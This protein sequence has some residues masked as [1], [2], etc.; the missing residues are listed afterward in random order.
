MGNST[1]ETVKK[2]DPNVPLKSAL[3]KPTGYS[4]PNGHQY[5]PTPYP[6]EPYFY[7]AHPAY[8]PVD[9]NQ[10]HFHAHSPTKI[11]R[12]LMSP[13]CFIATKLLLFCFRQYL[14]HTVPDIVIRIRIHIIINIIIITQPMIIIIITIIIVT[15]I[16]VDLNNFLKK[17]ISIF[18]LMKNVLF[19][20]IHL[21]FQHKNLFH[22]S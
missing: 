14:N 4:P 2:F 10:N 19:H 8:N 3:K 17:K 11:V 12:C 6:P 22:L 1:S 21:L 13:I 15:T 16:I 7:P 5:Y 18:L 9:S 20:L